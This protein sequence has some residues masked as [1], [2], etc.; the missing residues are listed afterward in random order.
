MNNKLEKKEIIVLILIGLVATVTSFIYYYVIRK[1]FDIVLIL[2]CIV[3]LILFFINAYKISLS[4]DKG[5]FKS[6]LIALLVMLFFFTF[7][8]IVVFSISFGTSIIYNFDLFL[9]V[10]LVSVFLSPSFIILLPI[11]WFIAEVLG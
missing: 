4:F 2:L 3:D 1:T 10:L 6:V 9:D 8:Q 7:I 5:R 11:I